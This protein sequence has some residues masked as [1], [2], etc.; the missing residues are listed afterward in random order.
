M[1]LDKTPTK[2]D[3]FQV[4]TAVLFMTLFAAVFLFIAVPKDD[5]T[6]FVCNYARDFDAFVRM[7]S[8]FPSPV[9]TAVSD[10]LITSKI[11]S[12]CVDAQGLKIFVAFDVPLTGEAHIQV[13]STG[14]DFFPSARGL[15]DTYETSMILT[16]PV[17]HLDLIIP[18]DSLPVGE[19]IFGNIIVSEESVSS[20]VAYLI[21]VSDCS[22]ASA[23][24]SN[25]SPTDIPVI[26]S[27]TCL[28]SKQLMIAFE[29]EKLVLGQYQALVADI[30]YQL[31]SVVSQPAVLFFAGDSPPEGPIV[32]RLVSAT[33][34]V[35]VFEE[36]Y[37]PPVCSDT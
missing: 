31:A 32:I 28:P 19:P 30:P 9:G 27:A 15:T 22:T 36:T 29:F 24:P 3:Q 4:M 13:F 18:V 7:C 14:P 35:V 34:Q 16:T 26:Q 11:N 2:S 33:D 5:I 20:Y 37:T 25:F 6:K 10:Q 8:N 23:P 21:N 17:D 12:A 1:S